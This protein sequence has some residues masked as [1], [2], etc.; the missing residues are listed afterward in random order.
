MRLAGAYDLRET[1]HERQ[2]TVSE[3]FRDEVVGT[4]LFKDRLLDSMS[5]T[6]AIE[7]VSRDPDTQNHV[8]PHIVGKQA[9]GGG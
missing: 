3:F 9:L 7:N 4:V 5:L 2:A 6:G 8:V 1:E